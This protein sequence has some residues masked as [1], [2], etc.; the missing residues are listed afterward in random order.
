MPAGTATVRPSLDMSA[1]PIRG[2][3]T[4]KGNVCSKL[5]MFHISQ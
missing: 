1:C 4:Q 3:V 2:L 5:L